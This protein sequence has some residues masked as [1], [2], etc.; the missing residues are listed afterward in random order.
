M[1]ALGRILQ[2]VGLLVTGAGFFLGVLG[3]NVRGEL[4]LLA[5]GAAIFFSGRFVQTRGGGSP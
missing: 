1:Y 2:L 5:L 3:G 4:A